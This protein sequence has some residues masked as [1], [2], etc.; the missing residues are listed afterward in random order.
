MQNIDK[1]FI[2]WGALLLAAGMFIG[3]Y[4]AATHDFK[5]GSVHAHL[6][7][8][9]GAMLMVFGLVYRAGLAKNDSWATIHLW[10]SVIG[11][12]AF[13]L[14][15][16]LAITAGQHLAAGVASLVVLLSGLLF[17]LNVFRA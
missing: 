1:H 14:A 12:I 16:Y 4:M 17:L 11:A 13:P 6:A 8:F 7:L 3:L 5:I 9:G 10:V 15:E 2:R